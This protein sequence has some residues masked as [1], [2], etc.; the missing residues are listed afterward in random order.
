MRK[1]ELDQ[2]WLTN[3]DEFGKRRGD[4]AHKAIKAQ[5]QI[6]P[7]SE[8]QVVEDLVKGLRELDEL[9]AKLS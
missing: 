4:V 7:K 3:L 9:I 8:L 2:L 5:Q 1:D 6:D